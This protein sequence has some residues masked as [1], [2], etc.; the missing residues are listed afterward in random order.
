MIA[1]GAGG[2]KPCVSAF[3]GDQFL[4]Q[5]PRLLS[6]AFSIFYFVINI[7]AVIAMVAIPLILEHGG[8]NWAFGVPGIL[9]AAATLVFWLGR[10][11]YVHAP[12]AR[13][14]DGRPGGWAIMGFALSRWRPFRSAHIL[15]ESVGRLLVYLGLLQAGVASSQLLPSARPPSCC[16]CLAVAMP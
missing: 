3:M 12:A 1:V 8:S 16:A 13:G 9:M 7:G 10:S 15:Q 4:G 11:S 2:I 6:G 5:D 14:N